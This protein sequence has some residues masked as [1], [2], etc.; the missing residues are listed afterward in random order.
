MQLE[1][2]YSSLTEEE[3]TIYRDKNWEGAFDLTYID[4]DWVHR[5]DSIQATFWELRKEDIRRVKFF[6][7]ATQKPSYMAGNEK[8]D[9]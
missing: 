3:R 5:G 9:M 1:R 7:T 4:N 2:E 8:H 6:T